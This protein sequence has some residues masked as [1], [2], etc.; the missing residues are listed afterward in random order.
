MNTSTSIRM[1]DDRPRAADTFAS[2]FATSYAGVVAFLAVA[3]EGSF[4]RA[5]DRLGID[6]SAVSRSVRKLEAQL[7]ARLFLR[8]TRNTSLTREGEIFYE[9]CLPGVERI[10]RALDD[11]RELRDGPPRGHL[12]I[13]ASPGFGRGVIAPL[14]HRFHARYPDITTELLLSRKPADF[15]GDRIDVA[16]HDGRLEDSDIVARQLI[17]MPWVVCASP[18]YV[19]AHGVP[20]VV[21][22]LDRHQCIAFREASGRLRDWEFKVGGQ[23]LRRRVS[24]PDIFNDLDLILQA[25]RQGRGVAQ[26]PG[27]LVGD[28]VRAGGL[29][30]CLAPYAP[31]D[32]GHYLCYLSRRHLPARIRVFADYVTEEIRSLEKERESGRVSGLPRFRDVSSLC[33][34]VDS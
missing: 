1:S 28:A 9:N 16:F 14:L 23:A 18:S 8:T 27:Y 3:R 29:I 31:D 26:L 4:S 6:R 19:A 12:A 24:G 32:G 21:G 15:A 20:R 11:M 10:V 13:Q 5:G 25:A 33:W 17:P 22:D 2:S 34:S 7:D 30:E